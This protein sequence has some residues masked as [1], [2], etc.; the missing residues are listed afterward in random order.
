MTPAQKEIYEKTVKRLAR[1]GVKDPTA[2][3]V[4]LAE[5]IEQYRAKIRNL[6]EYIQQKLDGIQTVCCSRIVPGYSDEPEEITATRLAEDIGRALLDH[7][8][9]NIKRRALPE[10]ACPVWAR[11][12][13]IAKT[14]VL[15]L[16][17]EEAKP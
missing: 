6:E 2:Q 15:P 11:S 10:H 5:E 16:K 9:T 4:A 17:D 13:Y 3:I 7:G 1:I 8:L 12:E 14:C